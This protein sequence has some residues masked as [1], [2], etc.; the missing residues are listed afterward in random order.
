VQL[1]NWECWGGATSTSSAELE[2]CE[3]GC[4]HS[5]PLLLTLPL[6]STTAASKRAAIKGLEQVNRAREALWQPAKRRHP[7][8]SAAARETQA[9]AVA[10]RVSDFVEQKR[11]PPRSLQFLIHPPPSVPLANMQ[12]S[13]RRSHRP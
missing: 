6:A 12:C 13:L 1:L 7:T 8:S 10:Q 2:Q 5:K 11:A 3:R 4:P 9:R